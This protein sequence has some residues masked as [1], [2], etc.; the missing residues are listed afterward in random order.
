MIFPIT[1]IVC[2]TIL[3][4]IITLEAWDM[5]YKV[6]A[7][8]NHAWGAAPTNII[9]RYMWGIKP[10]TPGFGLVEIKPQMDNVKNSSIL[11][12]TFRGQI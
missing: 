10:K 3:G 4:A 11:A 5:K 2:F 6:N 7:D 9:P 12:P 1:L 8:W